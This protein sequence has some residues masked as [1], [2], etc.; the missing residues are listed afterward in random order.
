MQETAPRRGSSTL[1]QIRNGATI[2]SYDK[3]RFFVRSQ[4]SLQRSP[5]ACLRHRNENLLP[6]P[7]VD[8]M[9]DNENTPQVAPPSEPTPESKPAATVEAVQSA[10][11]IP[12]ENNRN[13]NNSNATPSISKPASASTRGDDKP[14]KRKHTGF[15]AAK[16]VPNSVSIPHNL[17]L[18]GWLATQHRYRH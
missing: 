5:R 17:L 14:H 12:K 15:G 18:L 9:A 4:F 11:D 2:R 3:Q 1:I 13:S 6:T 7:P 10:E 16:Y 8:Q